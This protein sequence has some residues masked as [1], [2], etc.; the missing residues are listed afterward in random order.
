MA[1]VMVAPTPTA[2]P[3]MAAITGFVQSNSRSVN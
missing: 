1:R 3:L 2:G